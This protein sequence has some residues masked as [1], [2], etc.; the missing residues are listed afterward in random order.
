MDDSIFNRRLEDQLCFRLYRASNGLG[1][2]YT[3]ALKPFGLTFSQYLVLLALWDK[4]DVPVTNI[5]SRTG[6][7]IGTL[8]PILNRMEEHG[9][10][11]KTPHLSDKRTILIS[12][13][14]QSK[15][16][17]KKINDSVLEE[18]KECHLEGLDLLGLMQQ[19]QLLQ[20]Q[21]DKVNNEE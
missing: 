6:M 18:L 15:E 10:I 13:A 8:N 5:G 12:L 21:L 11:I 17:K 16:T 14:S 2:I 1:K 19:L 9:W 4:E 20:K 3:R 7:G